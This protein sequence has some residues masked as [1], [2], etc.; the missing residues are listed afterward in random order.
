M[1]LGPVW[2]PR[3]PADRPAKEYIDAQR[4]RRLVPEFRAAV[5]GVDVLVTGTTRLRATPIGQAEVDGVQVRPALLALAL[6]FNLTGWPAVSVPGAVDG[7]PVGVQIAAPLGRENLLIAVGAQLER[8]Q[9]WIER[10]PPTW[11]GATAAEAA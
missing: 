5:D 10:R 6:P 7:L 1:T 4:T 3:I 11:A 2:A 9:P 8:A